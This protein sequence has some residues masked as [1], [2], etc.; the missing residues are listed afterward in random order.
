MIDIKERD[1]SV[2]ADFTPAAQLSQMEELYISYGKAVQVYD[3]NCENR[4]KETGTKQTERKP[5][6]RR[7][8]NRHGE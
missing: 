2:S 5:E 7:K 6:E 1:D 4:R 3:N 8:G